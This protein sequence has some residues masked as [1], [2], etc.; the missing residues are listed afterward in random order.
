M[1]K[2][3]IKRGRKDRH[4]NRN[5]KRVQFEKKTFGTCVDALDAT[6]WDS[7]QWNKKYV[8]EESLN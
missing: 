8:K 4:I 5:K 3:R 6:E 1:G 2:Y 7:T